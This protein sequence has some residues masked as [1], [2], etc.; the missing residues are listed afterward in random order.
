MASITV[1][2]LRARWRGADRWL[3]DG[4]GRGGGRLVARITR[5]G[6]LLYFQYF[7]DGKRKWWP[8]GPYREE[9]LPAG[10]N[11]VEARNKAAELATMYRNGITDLHA[12]FAREKE[13][14]ERAR[15]EAEEARQRELEAAQRGTLKQ[16]LDAYVAHLKR[17][18]KITGKHV[19]GLFKR[20]VFE[21]DVALGAKRAS[22]V[23]VDEIV[24]LVAKLTEA[25][26]GRT[27]AILRSYLR[28]AYS[29]AIRSRTDPDAP[30]AMRAFG[31]TANPV[32]DIGAL[33]RYTKARD[34]VLSGPELVAY[35]ARLEKLPAGPV[36]DSLLLGVYLGGQRPAQLL[37]ARSAD[38][39][40][41]GETITLHD[42]KGARQ[43]PRVHVVPLVTE[44]SEILSPRLK[45]LKDGEP[46]FSTDTRTCLRPETI[47]NEVAEIVKKMVKAK[48]AREP[49]QLRD[50]RRTVETMLAGLKVSSD[51]RAELQS[52]G[53]GGVQKRHYDQH[54]YMREKKQALE[55]WARHIKQ[56]K[57][58][59]TAKVVP[60]RG[61][62]RRQGARA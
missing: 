17:Q 43:Q 14:Q 26:K 52:H 61:K 44:A 38:V 46:L 21:A 41:S 20:H 11:L 37:R 19:E 47:S 58:G 60:M 59:E 8:L 62:Q 48:E 23:T 22:D 3:S 7:N 5:D 18:G 36:R 34:R 16:M 28:A 12:H 39:D 29:L 6:P 27:A 40:L 15:R 57:T 9:G 4:G 55:T 1:T 54:K 32:A 25:G 45:A 49:F 31:V 42:P 56:L 24:A 33:S 50:V 35:L 53:L 2:A 10:M 51:V 13:A 30:L